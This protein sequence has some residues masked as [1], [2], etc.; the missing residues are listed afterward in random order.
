MIVFVY[1]TLR[2]GEANHGQLGGAVF[3]G[4]ATTPPAF[5]LV[6]LGAYPAMISGGCT[7]ITGELY[8]VDTATLAALDALEEHP[9]Y[10]RRTEV[11]LADGTRAQAYLLPRALAAEA[12][13][14]AGGDWCLRP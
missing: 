10:Y 2:R 6:H 1:G 4:P 11:A 12:P 8:Q 3:I 5:D 9:T 14:I 13:L 7:A